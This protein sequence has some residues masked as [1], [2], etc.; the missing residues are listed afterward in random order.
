M[1][2]WQNLSHH[3]SCARKIQD[4]PFAVVHRRFGV[5]TGLQLC[6][7]LS[8]FNATLIKKSAKGQSCFNK[9]DCIEM[10]KFVSKMLQSIDTEWCQLAHYG[11]ILIL[12]CRNACSILLAQV[13]V[14]DANLC[15]VIH[16]FMIF[17]F[18]QHYIML[19]RN[20]ICG[21]NGKIITMTLII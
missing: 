21:R 20:T 5:Y 14:W 19:K 7:I 18:L 11:T 17:P 13:S 3:L 15:D 4:Y 9:A 12:L 6:P 2:L 16:K 8:N 1:Q 10:C